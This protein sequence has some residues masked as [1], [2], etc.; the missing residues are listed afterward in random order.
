MFTSASGGKTIDVRDKTLASGHES[1]DNQ[2]EFTD[3]DICQF[4]LKSKNYSAP[5]TYLVTA[6]SGNALDHSR[7][8]TEDH[9]YREP[10]HEHSDLLK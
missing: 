7:S 6:E 8:L 9:E 2:F 4:N 10:G 5:G 3:D 1:D